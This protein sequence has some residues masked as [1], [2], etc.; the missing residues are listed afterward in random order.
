MGTRHAMRRGQALYEMMMGLF[1]LALV[2]SAIFAF[3]DYITTSLK[4]HRRL[5]AKAGTSAMWSLGSDGT[6]STASGSKS[7]NPDP[8]AA[9]HVFG[10]TTVHIRETV[11]MPS[12]GGI[13]L[14]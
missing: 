7:F 10:K 3:T 2:A 14:Q 4:L 5:R 1:V 8:M 9:E 6:L 12:M 11:K 13:I